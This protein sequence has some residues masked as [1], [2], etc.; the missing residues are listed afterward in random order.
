MATIIEQRWANLGAQEDRSVLGALP[1]TT[2]DSGILSPI[3]STNKLFNLQ[4]RAEQ[5]VS[6]LANKLSLPQN[7]E[8]VVIKD[9][10][11]AD[12]AILADGR[13]VRITG[14]ADTARYDAAEID[15]EL[16]E[17]AS[18]LDRVKNYFGMD[19]S[20]SDYATEMQKNQASMILGKPSNDIT[21]AD[22]RAVGDMQQRQFANDILRGKDQERTLEDVHLNTPQADLRNIN[23]KAVFVPSGSKDVYGREMGS[24]INPETGVNVSH[25]AS[26][27]AR[28]NAFAPD[29]MSKVAKEKAEGTYQG[30]SSDLGARLGESVDLAQSEALKLYA[31]ME[32]ATVS[33][34]RALLSTLGASDV[35]V[36]KWV[37]K[38]DILIGTGV[39]VQDLRGDNADATADR[40]SG[41]SSRYDW[42]K[43]QEIYQDLVKDGKHGEA[44]LNVIQNFDRYLATSATQTAAI[45]I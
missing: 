36:D 16:P 4:E 15:H 34:S 26:A 19:S 23:A 1:S 18:I 9:I 25:E 38:N 8:E 35:T 30:V 31:E 10:E 29:V 27:D 43:E 14:R 45:M 17:N 7:S 6:G 42:N 44:A 37:P 11:D 32:D 3:E 33:A 2:I 39:R 5:K 41:F 21:S 28:L 13:T 20:K 12:T 24:F 22:V 40:L